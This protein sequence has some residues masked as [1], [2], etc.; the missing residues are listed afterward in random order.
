[1]PAT[2]P[3]RGNTCSSAPC[4]Q[5]L[6]PCGPEWGIKIPGDSRPLRV[7]ANDDASRGS[8]LSRLLLL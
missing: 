5:Y 1:M 7:L 3:A 8:R 6:D 4:V 2:N